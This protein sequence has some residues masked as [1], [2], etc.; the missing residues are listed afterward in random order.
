MGGVDDAGILIVDDQPANVR[1]VEQILQQA[2][3]ANL[4]STTDPQRAV[5]LYAEFGP[6]LVLL[7][8][9]MPQMDGFE[10]MEA[11]AADESFDE[12]VPILVLTADVT[13]E[14]KQRALSMGARDFLTKPFDPAEVLLRIRNLLE[15]RYLYKQLREHSRGLEAT[16]SE[17][18]K[19]LRESLEQLRKTDRDRRALLSQLI[20]AQEAERERLAAEIHD[21][22][23]QAMTAAG[24][25]VQSLRGLLRDP[26]AT[27]V[28][29]IEDAIERAIKRLRYLVYE[30]HPAS[31]DRD[32]LAP[33]LRLH[34]SEIATE[35]LEWQLD[36]RLVEE[37]PIQTRTILYRIAQEAI[38]NVRL[39]AHAKHL[40][41]LL[42]ER[43]GGFFVGIT[44][45]GAGMSEEP[46]DDAAPH[47]GIPSM[48]ERAEL[49]G[50]W[51][52]L[53]SAPGEGTTVECWVP[54][55]AESAHPLRSRLPAQRVS[56]G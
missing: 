17:R 5:T 21:D 45:D 28:E 47:V 54:S 43:D 32:G 39:H 13:P 53:E 51:W 34:L 42:E 20:E 24:M 50:G 7:D 52:H 12:S 3:Y 29:E 55:G 33:A 23:L 18:T 40:R 11:L 30:L 22:S 37:P 44:D 9:L 27:A 49:A 8:L 46:G 19:E 56:E 41:I 48:R 4:R 35:G 38:S 36:N 2:G 16:V 10:V 14:A 15:T 6:D 26:D 25:R 31:L 1:L